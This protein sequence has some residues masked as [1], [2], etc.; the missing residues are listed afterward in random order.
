MEVDTVKKS[1]L[2]SFDSEKYKPEIRYT[3]DGSLPDEKSL[4]YEGPFRIDSAEVKAALFQDG[5]RGNISKGRFD[6]HKAVGKKVNYTNRY[7]GSYPAA[8][9]ITL[10]DGYR[11]GLTYGDGRWQGFLKNL[12][13]VIDMET[14]QLL[15]SV[16]IKF[17]QL[18]GPGVYMPQY[19]QVSVSQNGKDFTEVG[20]VKN[21]IPSDKSDLFFKNFT[22]NFSAEARYIRIFARKQ[23]GFM[24]T[25]E[26]VVY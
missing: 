9:E 17:M 3:L 7:S 15:H 22:V 14:V 12:D 10:T 13:V 11:G 24:F 2:V 4:L 23:A 20:Q 8:G 26:I 18:T 16:D 21:D 1:I 19:V 6:Y 5:K 25:D